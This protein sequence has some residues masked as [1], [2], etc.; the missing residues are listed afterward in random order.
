MRPV[1]DLK[2]RVAPFEVISDYEPS[3]DQPTAIED[4]EK[5]KTVEA[6]DDETKETA[7][8]VLRNAVAWFAARGVT[9]EQVKA[10]GTPYKVGKVP[11]Q[12]IA[13]ALIGGEY[14]GFAKVISNTENVGFAAALGKR[15]GTWAH[16]QLALT[17]ARYLSPPFHLWCNTVVR[18][19]MALRIA[20]DD[21][22]SPIMLKL[23]SR[24]PTHAQLAELDR[25]TLDGFARAREFSWARSVEKTRRVYDE[26]GQR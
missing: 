18:A 5:L 15:G 13:K 12:A 11:F 21:L 4:I 19:A 25:N 23:L 14:E 7:T 17:Y 20:G 10:A 9:A 6:R 8:E 1:T 16:W 2:R 26:V 22:G 3:G 24:W